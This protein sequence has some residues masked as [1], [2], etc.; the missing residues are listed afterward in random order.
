MIGAEALVPPKTSQPDAP[1]Y[2]VE[3]KTA[4]P[5]FGSTTAETSAL[6]LPLH[7]V[8]ADCHAGLVLRVEQ[9]LPAPLHAVSVQPRVLVALL[10]EVPPT[11]TTVPNEAGDST[12]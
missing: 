7:D 10:S 5:V 8:A 1:A 11:A 2:A 12:P 6:A 9:P 4:T 3:S